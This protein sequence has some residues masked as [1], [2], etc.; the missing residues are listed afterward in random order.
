MSEIL[1]TNFRSDVTRLFVD[2]ATT[3]QDYYLFVSAIS[4]FNPADS[5]FSKNQFLEKTL[6]GKKILPED[7]HFMIRFY[8][9]QKD[10]VYEEYDDNSDLT[11]RNFYAVV[12]PN[13]NDTGDYRV[14]KCLNNNNGAPVSNPPNFVETQPDQIYETADG[15]VWRY[16]YRITDLEFEAYNALGFIPIVD[17]FDVNPVTN[18]GGQVSSIIVENA[19]DNFGYSEEKGGLIGSPFTNGTMI[20]NPFTTWS[21][22]LNYYVGQYIYTQNPDGITS[23]LFEINFYRFNQ[24]T[25]N[26]EIRVGNELIYGEKIGEIQ[27]A[28]QANPVVITS[29]DHGLVSGQAIRF[30]N[31]GGM[32]ELEGT[33]Y[34]VSV[35]GPDSFSLRTDRALNNTLNGTGFSAFTSGGTYAATKDPVLSNVASNASFRILPKVKIQGDG[36][37]A[38]AIPEI[39]DSRITSISLLKS[40][41]GYNNIVAKV[42]D[43][44]FDFDPE[45]V[46][47]TDVRA[48]IRA[49]LTPEGGHAFNLIDELKCKHFSLYG[50]ITAEDNTK[51]GDTNTYAAVGIV[52]SPDFANTAP[53]VFDNRIAITSDDIDKVTVDTVLTQIDS[54][55]EVIFSAV[56]HEVDESSNTFYLA[57]YMGPFQNNTLAGK[58][59]TSLDLSLP[60]NNETGQTIRINTPIENNIVFSDYVQRTG[61]V[62]FMQRFFPLPRTDLSREEFKFVLEF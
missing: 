39:N 15:Y 11:D 22:I 24:V 55:R 42:V 48:T 4:E 57:E 50:Y 45:D 36:R 59:D 34:Y 31:V 38:V 10:L 1:S 28:T 17:D 5:I 33:T 13:D 6:F 37:G 61:E 53:V 29:L 2:D 44:L 56:V 3:N 52:R 8:P 47:T 62:Y 16:M 35:N 27:N 46:T 43:P 12:G 19:A 49:R 25:G 26:A 23:N 30:K 60:F 40:G 54:N 20:V 9:W 41:T 7:I 32:T 14:Y 58:G 51:I 21:P 18:E